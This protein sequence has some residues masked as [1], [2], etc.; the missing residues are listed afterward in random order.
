M[1]IGAAARLS[2]TPIKTIRHY[3]AI[4]LLPAPPRQG[5]YRLY[6]QQ[7]LE[8]LRFIRCARQLGFRLKDMHG[9]FDGPADRRLPW[10]RVQEAMAA[11]HCEIS[12]Q[13]VALQRQQADLQAFAEQLD[14]AREH[15]PL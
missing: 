1:Y 5:A 3:E 9:L 4:G 8:Q 14:E 15:C 2:G 13:I 11:R 10:A 6:N 12:A 7:S